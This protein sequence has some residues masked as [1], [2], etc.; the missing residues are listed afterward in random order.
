MQVLCDVLRRRP[1]LHD[2]GGD[3]EDRQADEGDTDGDRHAQVLPSFL[4]RV[5]LVIDANTVRHDDK[6][7]GAQGQRKQRDEVEA[8]V[9]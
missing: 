1:A 6:A 9:F 2:G 5:D 4:V 3:D 8:V 7:E